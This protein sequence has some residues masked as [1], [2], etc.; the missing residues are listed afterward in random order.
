M[1]QQKKER[2]P[3]K[4]K[5]KK[6]KKP[7]RFPRGANQSQFY[8]PKTYELKQIETCI[9]LPCLK[10]PMSGM[11]G[12]A[13]VSPYLYVSHGSADSSPPVEL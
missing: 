4:R 5:K 8:P 12:Q 2:K 6:K 10:G 1:K 11:S 9:F 3:K 7:L 13:A